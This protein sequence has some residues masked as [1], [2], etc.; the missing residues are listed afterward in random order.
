[1]KI[2]SKREEVSREHLLAIFFF[3]RGSSPSVILGDNWRIAAAAINQDDDIDSGYFV[4]FREIIGGEVKEIP[5][6]FNE[7]LADRISIWSRE[8]NR[9][10]MPSQELDLSKTEV[11]YTKYY[12]RKE[13]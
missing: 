2:L 8:V 13:D 4:G 3:Y 6:V 5:S 9:S 1:M 11:Y 12:D 10:L 7:S